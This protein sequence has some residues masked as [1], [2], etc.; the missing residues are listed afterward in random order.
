MAE[1]TTRYLGLD[2]HKATIAVAVAEDSG[3]PVLFGTI[4]N[5][6]KAVRKMVSR[7]GRDARLV[8]P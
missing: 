2:V 7:L 4:V 8:D 6:P 5:E 3:A 1:R